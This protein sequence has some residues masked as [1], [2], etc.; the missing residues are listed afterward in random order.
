[1]SRCY[2]SRCRRIMSNFKIDV[3]GDSATAWSRWTF[4][5]GARGP[6]I[7]I[8][9]R[10]EDTLVREDGAWKFKSRQAFNDVTAP[11]AAPAA[12]GGR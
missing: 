3:K 5:S 12:A 10:Y 2:Q 8:A 4:V 11:A 9:G 7:Q 1:M 6:G